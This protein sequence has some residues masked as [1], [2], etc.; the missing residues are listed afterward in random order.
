M[1]RKASRPE[2]IC[3]GQVHRLVAW[4]GLLFGETPGRR[5]PGEGGKGDHK[6]A[7]CFHCHLSE[8]ARVLHTGGDGRDARAG[9]F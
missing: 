9:L 6:W 8:A 5:W 3:S 2:Y 1:D 7:V 4:Q